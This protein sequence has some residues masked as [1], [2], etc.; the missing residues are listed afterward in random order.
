MTDLIRGPWHQTGDSD[1]SLDTPGGN[2]CTFIHDENDE[3][4]AIV[5]VDH[6]FDK[7]DELDAKAALVASAPEMLKALKSC[8]ANI[9]HMGGSERSTFSLMKIVNAAIA[10][11]EGGAA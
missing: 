3:P 9:P 5:A 2:T 7:D 8:A 1:W 6:S 4:V 11:A 10:K